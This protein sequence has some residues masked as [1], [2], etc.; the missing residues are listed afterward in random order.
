[1]HVFNLRTLEGVQSLRKVIQMKQMKSILSV[2]LTLSMAFLPMQ[3]K[4]Q[5]ACSDIAMPSQEYLKSLPYMANS[6]EVQNSEVYQ[7][8][9]GSIK[10]IYQKIIIAQKKNRMEE[11]IELI[12]SCQNSNTVLQVTNWEQISKSLSPEQVDEIKKMLAQE[13]QWDPSAAILF[14]GTGVGGVGAAVFYVSVLAEG[15]A[16]LV[17]GGLTAMVGGAVAILGVG[18]YKVYR[19]ARGKYRHLTQPRLDNVTLEDIDSAS[20]E[21]AKHYMDLLVGSKLSPVNIVP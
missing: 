1:M 9:F 4:A 19:W 8:V 21:F 10:N 14:S 15:A 17:F 7:Q 18:G 11:F 13:P 20:K 5:S 12:Q 2:V 16:V 6:P 3:V